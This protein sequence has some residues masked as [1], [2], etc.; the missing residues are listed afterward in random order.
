[1]LTHRTQFRVI[2]GDT[3]SMGV[4]Y[5]A[6]YLR[7]F[8]IGRTELFRFLG[9]PYTEIEKKGYFLPVSETHCKFKSFARYDDIMTIETSYDESIKAGL[10]FDYR[11]FKDTEAEIFA[12]GFTRHAFLDRTG[13]VVRTPE[14][15]REFIAEKLRKR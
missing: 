7:W 4:V 11:I 13:K 6:N 3:D 2:Y 10:K 15:I 1:M 9:L 8:E 5:Y 12:T 14:F